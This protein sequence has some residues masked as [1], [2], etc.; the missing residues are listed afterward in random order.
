MIRL[1]PRCKVCFKCVLPRIP[2]NREIDP[3][4]K[5]EVQHIKIVTNKI[6]NLIYKDVRVD[7]LKTIYNGPLGF[8]VKLYSKVRDSVAI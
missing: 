6:L 7:V 8:L 1:V 3:G 4:R 2:D 5:K